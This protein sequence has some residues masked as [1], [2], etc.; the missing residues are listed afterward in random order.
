MKALYYDGNSAAFIPDYKKPIP[1][2][3]ESLIRVIMSAICNTDKEVL[4]GYKPDFRGIM[5]HEFVGIV[6]ESDNQLLIGKRVVGELNEGCQT[7]LYCTS[8]R[9][10]HCETRKVIGLEKKDG[11]FAE[12]MTI[13]TH[14]LHE[15]PNDIPDEIAIF[16]E[17]LAAALEITNRISIR[18]EQNIAIIGDG[19]LSL[20]ITQV[21]AL[22]GADI[23]VIGRHKEKLNLFAPYAKTVT[24][25]D[26]NYEIVVDASGSASGLE[27]ATKIVRKQG[28]IILKSTYAGAISL[29]MSYYVI[30]EISII[31]S[32]CGPF[33]PALQ[34]LKKGFISLPPIELYKLEHYNE[35]FT[36]KAWK[37]GFL[38]QHK[39]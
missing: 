9:E 25:T 32:R 16:T 36:S 24:E 29:E 30:N 21:L 22:T 3:N 17:P 7:C 33:E 10:K 11:C 27:L 2:E 26:S 4:R 6:E 1:R 19:R 8:G 35:A 39:E 37:S 5:G 13:A 20:L 15:V 18:P 28:K 31:G 14:L 23:T 34:L 38:F 12:Y